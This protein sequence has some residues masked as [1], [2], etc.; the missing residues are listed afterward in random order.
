MR[1]SAPNALPQDLRVEAVFAIR[2]D[3]GKRRYASAK[4]RTVAARVDKAMTARIVRTESPGYTCRDLGSLQRS[5][6][7][8][9]ETEA[10]DVL[11]HDD[12]FGRDPLVGV[13]NRR[14][15]LRA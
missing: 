4:I 7:F 1:E 2:V 10:T 15:K 9:I 14:F 5:E 8:S 3:D 13:T 12:P 6:S 11:F